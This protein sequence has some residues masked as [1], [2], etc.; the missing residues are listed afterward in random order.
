M[1]KAL[2]AIKAK[3]PD[4]IPVTDPE[5]FAERVI[6]A[7][8]HLN[9]D[10]LREDLDACDDAIVAK[11]REKVILALAAMATKAGLEIIIPG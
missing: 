11:D 5:G 6:A 8:E 4:G 1:G 7:A 10:D 2:D 9:P 3:Y